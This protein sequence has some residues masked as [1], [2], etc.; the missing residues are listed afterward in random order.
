MKYTL[1]H[2]VWDHYHRIVLEERLLHLTFQPLGRCYNG[3]ILHAGKC[4]LLS[5]I[6]LLRMIA[7]QRIWV[8]LP[9]FPT[10]F[11]A[12]LPLVAA[13]IIIKCTVSRIGPAIVQ[14]PHHWLTC[15]LQIRK[16]FFHLQDKSMYIVK[17]DHIWIPFSDL[18]NELSGL[19]CGCK[20]MLSAEKGRQYM[21]S[22]IKIR[23]KPECL[24]AFW[25]L[26]SSIGDQPF[27]TAAF[28][29]MVNIHR[30]TSHASASAHCADLQYLHVLS[31][32][33]LPAFQIYAILFHKYSISEVIQ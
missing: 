7:E 8:G 4:S 11:T 2:T 6:I 16:Q 32:A 21:K 24:H 5:H 15:L 10:M 27:I 3:Q 13:C 20:A 12:C 26:S 28:Q 19:P 14:G 1:I 23:S 17:M 18:L 22:H 29:C 30:D 25:C 33:A 9:I 31:F